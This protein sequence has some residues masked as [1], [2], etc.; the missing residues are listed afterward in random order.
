MGLGHTY[1]TRPVTFRS[2]RSSGSRL[3][4][5]LWKPQS[6]ALIHKTPLGTQQ[7]SECCLQIPKTPNPRYSCAELSFFFVTPQTLARGAQARAPP[8]LSPP[9]PAAGHGP[10]SHARRAGLKGGRFH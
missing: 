8:R 1:C 3:Y 10:S 4:I 5:H 7:F 9:A 6:K 2:Q